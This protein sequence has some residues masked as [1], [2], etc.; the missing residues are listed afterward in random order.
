MI[1]GRSPNFVSRTFTF[2]VGS[3]TERFEV[4]LSIDGGTTNCPL[5]VVS[6]SGQVL[7]TI[8]TSGQQTV[9]F[10][11]NVGLLRFAS[12]DVGDTPGLRIDSLRIFPRAG[13]VGPGVP[14]GMTDNLASMPLTLNSDVLLPFPGEPMTY[15]LVAQG[16]GGRTVEVVLDG[17]DVNGVGT[18]SLLIRTDDF[19]I[20]EDSAEQ[21][22]RGD[23]GGFRQITLHP[24]RDTLFMTVRS[25]ATAG[26]ARVSVNEVPATGVVS[27]SARFLNPLPAAEADIAQ[28]TAIVNVASQTLYSATAGR[29]RI[30]TLTIFTR[31]TAGDPTQGDI[32]IS[33]LTDATVSSA[34][35]NG[36]IGL[37]LGPDA[38]AGG[39]TLAPE[40]LT[41]NFP[42][43]PEGSDSDGNPLCLNS[44]LGGDSFG[45]CWE[46]NHNPTGNNAF[47]EA[48]PNSAWEILAPI[49]NTTSPTSTPP[50]ILNNISTVTFPLTV[51]RVN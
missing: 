45:L 29:M 32:L 47:A 4:T 5:S 49:L 11:G 43:R 37:E 36:K 27:L 14:A 34:L 46:R 1:L 18:G 21:I 40:I 2:F 35:P 51:F 41:H 19:A 20:S 50:Q 44:I 3:P 16:V 24:E 15:F 13:A 12:E 38:Q 48:R 31:L 25:Q 26:L 7:Q 10:P 39:R 6:G 42:L 17:P 23:E 22:V 8:T 33:S 9:Q 28:L 30:G